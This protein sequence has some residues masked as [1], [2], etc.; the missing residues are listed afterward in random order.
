MFT[1]VKTPHLISA[2]FSSYLWHFSRKEPTLYLTF[3][4]GPTPKITPWV[5]DVLKEF[6]VK[7]TFFC[8]GKNVV[9]QPE[10]FNNLL[11][12]GH[13][14]GN[15]TF[16]HLNGLKTDTKTYLENI[17]KTQV[18]FLAQNP[19]HFETRELL[20]RPPYGKCFPNQLKALKKKG[21]KPVFWDVISRDFDL[22]INREDCLNNVLKHTENGSIVVF[23]DSEKAFKNL[24]YTLPKI[25]D[26]FK[27]KAYQFNTI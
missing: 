27:A 5:L 12:D 24:K 8:I 16:N 7:A 13:R 25:L 23:H 1:L 11:A 26:H 2:T 21:Y 14:V 6:E 9:A 22:N 3:D 4:D 18:A 10:I 19:H 15:H 20:F 17:E